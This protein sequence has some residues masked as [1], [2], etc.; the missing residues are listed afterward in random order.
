MRFEMADEPITLEDLLNRLTNEAGNPNW[1]GYLPVR[2]AVGGNLS[3]PLVG[4]EVALAH[5]QPHLLLQLDITELHEVILGQLNNAMRRE[6]ENRAQIHQEVWDFL[7][8]RITNKTDYV[9]LLQSAFGESRAYWDGKSDEVIHIIYDK[10]QQQ[11]DRAK[12]EQAIR[13]CAK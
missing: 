3:V 12:I 1:R 11:D 10:M 5:A 9:T 4:V 8:H 13:Y 6:S 2:I 7:G